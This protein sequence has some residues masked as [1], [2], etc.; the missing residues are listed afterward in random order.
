MNTLD[1]SPIRAFS[2]FSLAGPAAVNDSHRFLLVETLERQSESI[3]ELIAALALRGPFYVIAGGEWL[4]GYALTRSLR[5]KTHRVKQCLDHLILARPF[6]C[7]QVLDLL[8]DTR[9]G[10]EPILILDLLHHFY[11]DD[12]DLAV[13]FRVFEQ[14]CKHLQRLSLFR[15]VLVFAQRM[16]VKHYQQFFS[17]LTAIADETFQIEEPSTKPA[18]LALF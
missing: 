11:N 12:V 5:A 9:P 18:Q 10:S 3:T 1:L 13:R 14:S 17:L 4:P 15:P 2:L 7:Y 8:N 6:T 16:P